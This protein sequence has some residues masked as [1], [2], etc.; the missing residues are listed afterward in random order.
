EVK[1]KTK[2]NKE[3]ILLCKVKGIN[4]NHDE[5]IIAGTLHDITED[6]RIRHQLEERSILAEMLIEN[7]VDMIAAYNNDLHLI[8]WNKRCEQWFGR[9]KE[10]VM[11]Q[12]ILEVFPHFKDKAI[13]NQLEQVKQGKQFHFS[14]NKYKR[15]EG[16]YESFFIPLKNKKDKILG[17]LVIIHDITDI[18]NNSI[19]LKHLNQSLI[20]KNEEFERTNQELA[21]FSYVASHDLQEPLR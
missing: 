2:D 11:G 15:S 8:A 10:E 19:K 1:I 4:A 20:K 17:I 6:V 9:T 12:H 7:S 14:D 18:K 21:S 3:R 16:F 13:M 5:Q